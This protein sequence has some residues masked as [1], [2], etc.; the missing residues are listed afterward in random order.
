MSPGFE[1]QMKSY[2]TRFHS[3]SDERGNWARRSLPPV[4]LT[5]SALFLVGVVLLAGEFAAAMGGNPT[6]IMNA[7]PSFEVPSVEVLPSVLP[8]APQG[9]LERSRHR[10]LYTARRRTVRGGRLAICVRLCDGLYFPS[11][12]TSGGDEACASQCPDAPTAFYSM[13]AGSDK[14]DDAV[15]LT[16]APYSALPVANRHQTSFDNTCTCHRSSVTSYIAD[17]LH[18]RTLRD[19]DLVMTAKGF[20]VF[21]GDKSGVVQPSNFVALSPSSS[22]AKASGAELK[23][24]ES[25]GIWDRQYGPYSYSAPAAE[26]EQ[27]LIAARR[28]HKGIVTVDDGDANP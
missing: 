27:T 28:P 20:R 6:A 19:G 10:H 9:G 7:A 15:S 11:V 1:E 18:D 5:G 14:I 3:V 23:A 17:L 26:T 12:V 24:M 22:V 2:G 16:G 4:L 8:M 21:K 25:A 13:P